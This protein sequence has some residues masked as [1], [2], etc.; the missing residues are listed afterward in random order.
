MS[1]TGIILSKRSEAFANTQVESGRYASVSEVVC[2]GLRVL[3]EREIKA[4]S[5]RTALVE[6]EN[7]GK[8]DYSLAKLT[9]ELDK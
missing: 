5:L 6:G 1:D 4:E 9:A 8:A 3:E 7:S 2:A